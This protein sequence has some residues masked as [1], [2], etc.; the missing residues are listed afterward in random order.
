MSSVILIDPFEKSISYVEMDM[1]DFDAIYD[2]LECET[3]DAEVFGSQGDILV[4][5]DVGLLKN[6]DEQEYFE[7]LIRSDSHPVEMVLFGRVLIAGVDLNEDWVSPV[8][9]IHDL[10]EN[11]CVVWLDHQLGASFAQQFQQLT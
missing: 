10:N 7:F 8:C 4:F 1:N 9:S 6:T 5:D 11:G 2:L 3:F